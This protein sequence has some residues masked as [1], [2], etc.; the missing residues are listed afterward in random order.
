[1]SGRTSLAWERPWVELTATSADW[2]EVDRGW[3]VRTYKTIAVIRRF[4]ELLLELAA[5]NLVHGPMHS[6][7][8]QEGT[9]AAAAMSMLPGDAFTG[10]H[11]GHHQFLAKALSFLDATEGALDPNEPGLPAE[12]ALLLR[13]TLSEILGLSSGFSGGRG[14]SMH[15]RWGEA[16]CLG[17]N[18]IVGGGVPFAVGHSWVQQRDALATNSPSN[19]SFAYFGDGAANIGSV[20]ESMNLAAAWRLP[21]CFFVENN[22]YA[23]ATRI[24]EV[25]SETRLSARGPG[26]GIPSWRVDGMDPLAVKLATDEALA[27]MR[28]G[29]GPTLIEAEVYRYYHQNGPFPGSAFGY[30]GRDEEAVWRARDP[31]ELMRLKMIAHG[32]WTDSQA[33]RFDSAIDEVLSAVAGELLTGVAPKRSIDESL[34]PD[35][36]TVDHGIRSDAHELAGL[37]MV[38]T[39]A[40]D[41]EMKFADAI[42]TVTRSQME[43]DSSVVILGEDIHRLKGGTNGATKGL[44][45]QFPDRVLATPISENAFAG[46]AGGM[47]ATGRVR[48]IVEFMF[49]DFI[50]V[51]ADQLFNQIGKLRHMFGGGTDVP[52][53]LRVKVGTGNGYGSQHSMDPASIFTNFAG[54]RVVAPSTAADY[55]GAF[56]TALAL[57]D[58]VA[59]LEHVLLYPVLE[60]V[61]ADG[62]EYGLPLGSAALRRVGSGAT[63]IGYLQV[64]R[65]LERLAAE[66]DFDV[67]V[68]DLRWLDGASLDW[69]VI[70]RSVEKTGKV[71]IV[72][73]GTGRSSYGAW[74]GYEIQQRFFDHLDHPVE[75]VTGS[76]SSPTVSLPLER[77]AVPGAAVVVEAIE[78]LLALPTWR[79]TTGGVP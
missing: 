49:A 46:A 28:A 52:L 9:V 57:N 47:A 27:V 56:N 75:R 29:G 44:A 67:D 12:A 11:R 6:S 70:E 4:E 33:E 2:Q 21:T 73:Q 74:L 51:A 79:D 59:I 77:A 65:L 61:P 37:R 45:E 42:A 68:V 50:L 19:V 60:R 69:S 55:V 3:L 76:E 30:R 10:T 62:F 39:P 48:P 32:A 26:F 40:Q 17:T 13:R 36:A 38:A 22:L 72:E 66:N 53:V 8:G 24:D 35:P 64:S 41:A 71:L 25:S 16:G 18:A 43:I 5:E 63:V 20:L 54:W 7:I 34:W 1:M 58:P 31:L 15:L 14:G 78:R 23:V